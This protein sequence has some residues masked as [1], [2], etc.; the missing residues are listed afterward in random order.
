MLSTL[1]AV[2]LTKILSLDV[3][4][5][6]RWMQMPDVVPMLFIY[7]SPITIVLLCVT[8]TP[9]TWF[10]ADLNYLY[11]SFLSMIL[12]KSLACIYLVIVAGVKIICFG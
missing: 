3:T 9:T 10:H 1:T 12:P 2:K 6:V 5:S 8:L 4:T 7:Q 11:C